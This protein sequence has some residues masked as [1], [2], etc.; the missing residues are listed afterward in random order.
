MFAEDVDLLP[1]KMFRRMLEHA[2][3][4]PEEFQSVASDLFG[5]MKAGGR[6]GFEHVAWVNGGLFDDDDALSLTKEEITLTMCAANSDWAEI[7][8]SIF[9]T[10]SNA[11]SIPTSAHNLARTTPIATRLC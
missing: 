5:A 11:G 3:A 4:R 6:I 2:L 8:P 10:C 7:D 9:G 1:N